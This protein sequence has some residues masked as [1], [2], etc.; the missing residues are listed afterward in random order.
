MK[1]LTQDLRKN[2]PVL[3]AQEHNRVPIVYAKFFTPWSN[4]SWY[5]TEFDGEDLF[6]G[7][8]DGFEKELGYFSL[9][10]LEQI[11][12]PFGLQIERDIHFSSQPLSDLFPELYDDKFE[13]AEQGAE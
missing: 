11:S 9:S 5:V 8:V 12:G 13:N 10:E 1:L 7:L 3:Y 4:W 2:I 6:F